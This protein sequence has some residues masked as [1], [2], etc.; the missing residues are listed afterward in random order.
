MT[1]LETAVAVWALVTVWSGA[2]GLVNWSTSAH[3]TLA[4]RRCARYVLTCWA[5]PLYLVGFPLYGLWL[6]VSALFR[7]AF[8]KTETST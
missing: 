1:G 8:E 2:V 5:W 7:S 4:R 6:L 3:G